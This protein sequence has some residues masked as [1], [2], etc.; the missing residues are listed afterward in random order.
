M[1]KTNQFNE[2]AQYVS[3]SCK[4]VMLEASAGFMNPGSPNYGD[5]GRAGGNIT[6]DEYSDE[7]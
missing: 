2:K 5:A 1:I 4:S 3:P 7:F 6:W